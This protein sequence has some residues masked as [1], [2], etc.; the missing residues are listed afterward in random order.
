MKKSE[1]GRSMVEMLGT[2]A[3]VGVLSIGG[4]AGYSYGIDK[5][6]ANTIMNDVN[7]RAVDLIAQVNRGGDISLSEWPEK[8]IANYNIGLEV[9]ATTNTTEGGIY[10]DKIPQRICEIISDLTAENIELTINGIDK[11]NTTCTEENKIIFYYNAITDASGNNSLECTGP[12]VNGKCE[13]CENPLVWDGSACSC[14]GETVFV[15]SRNTCEPCPST[16]TYS[17]GTCTCSGNWHYHEN[18]N[19]C[20]K[21]EKPSASTDPT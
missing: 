15:Q 6:R 5:Y 2:L 3:I 14:P 7:L 19:I 8:S 16:A 17:N 21:V 9:D 10:V 12:I 13:P 1:I 20:S 4:I 18:S 11:K